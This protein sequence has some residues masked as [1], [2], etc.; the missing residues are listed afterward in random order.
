MTTLSTNSKYLHMLNLSLQYPWLLIFTYY[1]PVTTIS[2]T[3]KYLR[4]LNLWLHYSMVVIGPPYVNIKSH[5]YCSDR[6]NIRNYLEFMD[7]LHYSCFL[8][9]YTFFTVT[10]ISVTSKYLR[11][12][13]LWL[14]YPYGYCSD[15]FNIRNYLEFMDSVITD[16]T[17]V[18]N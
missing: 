2:V 4:I 17:Y 10:T 8:D 6:F 3:S 11:M 9:I 16:A 14:Q 18:N 1:G 5:G 12:L 7:R 13:D 15:R